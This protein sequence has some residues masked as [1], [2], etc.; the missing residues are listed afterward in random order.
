MSKAGKMSARDALMAKL[1]P[2]GISPERFVRLPEAERMIKIKAAAE[3]PQRCGPEVVAAPGRGAFVVFTPRE[4]VPGSTERTR[5]GF[6]GRDAVRAGDAFDVMEDAA[7]KAWL[8]IPEAER[9]PFEPPFTP[10]QISMGR[11]YL[12]LTERHDAGGVKCA[13]LEG[14]VGGGGGDGG[15]IA[16]YVAEGRELGLL[17]RRIGTGVALSVRRVRPSTRGEDA[18]G[19]I[20][21]RTLVDMVCLGGFTL[22]DVL[23][24]HGWA[25]AS[26][27]RS[28]LRE[29]LAEALDRMRGYGLAVT[30]R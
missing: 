9:P 13:A 14:R 4:M 20:L 1:A 12:G 28:A 7:R 16:A 8:R 29:A 10:G 18:R 15:F 11:Y 24:R 21:D 5:A 17:H 27:H 19:L 6:A 26:G 23:R 25:T 22:N 3:V 2:S 30:H